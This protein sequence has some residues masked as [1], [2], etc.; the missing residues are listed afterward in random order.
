MKKLL[1]LSLK[2][3]AEWETLAFFTVKCCPQKTLDNLR[4]NAG[5]KRLLKSYFLAMTL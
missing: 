5:E 1:L 3:Q 4:N 2:L